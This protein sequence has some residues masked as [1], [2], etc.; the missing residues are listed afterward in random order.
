VNSTPTVSVVIICQDD[1]ERLPDAI[2]SAMAQSL[3]DIEII[4]V[5]HGSTDDSTAVAQSFAQEDS[6]IRVITLPD[7]QGKPGRPL[8]AGFD[9]AQAPWV[10]AIGSDDKLRIRGCENA[11]AAGEQAN[12]DLVINGVLRVDVDTGETNRWMPGV[13]LRSRVVTDLAQLPEMMRD[14][15]GGFKLYRTD[16]LRRN[17]IRFREDIFYQDQ[18]F[19]ARCYQAAQVVAIS[20]NYMGRWRR[21]S[22]SDRKSITQRKFTVENLSDRFEANRTI[23]EVL[24]A[25]DRR[26]MLITKHQKFFTHDLG[27]H[28]KD[29]DK[30]SAEYQ[31]RLV[32]LTQEYVAG[33]PEEAFD[34]LP[35]NR[36][37]MLQCLLAGEPAEAEEAAAAH[38]SKILIEWQRLTTE[39][40]DYAI[41]N[42]LPCEPIERYRVDRYRLTKIPGGRQPVRGWIS[43]APGK[44][45]FAIEV[46]VESPGRPEMDDDAAAA[47]QLRN[48]R[49]G[50]F[51]DLPLGPITEK[52]GDQRTWRTHISTATLTQKFGHGEVTLSLYAGFHVGQP[53]YWRVPL[54]PADDQVALPATSSTQPWAVDVVDK[55][56]ELSRSESAG[57]RDRIALRRDVRRY[58]DVVT[59][60]PLAELTRD[61]AADYLSDHRS[62]PRSNH[63]FFESFAGRRID[64]APWGLSQALRR[65]RPKW[66]QAWSG[67][68]N[69]V[70]GRPA[71]TLAAPRFT[72][73]YV[74]VLAKS[75]VWVDNGW[76]PFDPADRVFLQLGSGVPLTRMTP[77]SQQPQWTH[78]VTSG[79][80]MSEHLRE[81]Y[82]PSTTLLASGSPATD[83]LLTPE[84]Q[85]RRSQLRSRWGV[86]DRTVL[87]FLPALRTRKIA[88]EF[89]VPNLHRL[90]RDLGA[91]YYLFF[92][93]HDDDATGKRTAG[94]PDDL[95]WFAGGLR[96]RGQLLD[97]LL[98]ADILISDYSSI[99][100][101]FGWTGRTVIHY[102]PDQR[103]YEDEDPGAYVK[104]D[105]LAAG[106]VVAD[107]AALIQAIREA[108]SNTTS[109]LAGSMSR[110]FSEELAPLDALSSGDEI[111]KLMGW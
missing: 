26:D 2:Q 53:G 106:P 110:R 84:A 59:R 5:D 1:A 10:V 91:N 67:S 70:F 11:L 99:I 94:V 69:S 102:A 7:R 34:G 49:D 100:T 47:L 61:Q 44:D 16:F 88:A 33:I 109:D 35:L 62:R 12:A 96:S 97:Y 79:E 98:A 37:I 58:P 56:V 51:W 80:Y 31:D 32:E 20:A 52:V 6:R 55:R 75:G 19:T 101:D 18:I 74:D 24:T 63:I 73:R 81:I 27:I 13:T 14:T 105:Q 71:G 23:D 89:R 9:A 40:S 104:L 60:D 78:L 83:A 108:T 46:T 38:F 66:T 28:V 95:R 54:R 43:I 48:P 103:F 57:L 107:D 42:G 15:I 3:T 64:G 22:T 77:P 25:H 45:G 85:E 4:V 93:E 68:Q 21:W 82:G 86:A 90:S 8:N 87:L 50:R 65:S 17:N 76:L 41:P 36:W 30:T 72:R 39:D 92:R 29:L 111:I